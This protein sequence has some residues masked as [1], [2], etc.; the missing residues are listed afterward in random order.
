MI[1]YPIQSKGEN[2]FF[3]IN[4]IGYK[5]VGESIVLSVKNELNNILWC[6]IIDCF[7][8]KG[9]NKTKNILENYGYGKEHKKLD[10]LCISHPDLD[11]IKSISKIIEN[12]TDD[13]TMILMPNFKDSD[14]NQTREIVKI[15]QLLKSKFEAKYPRNMIPDNIFFNRQLSLSNLKWEFIS[16]T[17]KYNMQI[18][19][20]TPYDAIMLNS[21]NLK[22]QQF[23]NDFSICLK[24]VFNDNNFLFMGDCTD[25]V[26]VNLDE[27]YLPKEL[28]FLKLPHHGCKNDT[29][30]SFIDYGIIEFID[31]SGCTYRK[32]TTQEAT[33]DFYSKR[34]NYISITGNI[35][36]S[37][38]TYSYGYISHI[39]DVKT[40]EFLLDR[41]VAEGNA[42]LKCTL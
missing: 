10:F 37:K 35:D 3:E 21:I 19:S 18:E 2:L 39:Y 9:H 22:Y 20:L 34:S 23:K 1:R 12:F 38:N 7:K 29:M 17:K 40:G 16:K 24:I 31:V 15:K 30:E 36:S 41:S 5:N 42:I 33:L 26:L 25:A 28:S 6:G 11:H 32:N 14:I 4:V 8:Y 27:S 13:E